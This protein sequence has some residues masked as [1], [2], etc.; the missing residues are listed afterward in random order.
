LGLGANCC[1]EKSIRWDSLTGEEA[2]QLVR[3]GPE[4]SGFN[5]FAVIK[6]GSKGPGGSLKDGK[7]SNGAETTSEFLGTGGDK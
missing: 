3:V 5:C 1:V 7:A 6:E 4:H 2:V